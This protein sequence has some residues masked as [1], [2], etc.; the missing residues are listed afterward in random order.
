MCGICGITR[1][2][3]EAIRKMIKLL[4]HRGPEDSGYYIDDYI[5][6][7]HTRLSIIDI[8]GGHQPMC[9]EDGSIWVIMNGEIFNYKELRERLEK[10]HQFNTNSDTEVLIHLYEEFGVNMVSSLVG[11]FAFAIWDSNEKVLLLSRDRMGICPMYYTITDDNLIFSSEIK[12]ILAN[13]VE[14]EINYYGLAEYLIFQSSLKPNTLFKGIYELEPGSV[15]I[16]KENKYTIHKYWDIHNFLPLNKPE[17]EIISLIYHRLTESVKYSLVSDVPVGIYLSGGIDSSIVLGIM[18][19]EYSEDINAFNLS[20][21]YEEIDEKEYA[22]IVA[23]FNNVN[24]NIL[25]L[26]PEK[27]VHNLDRI[28]FSMEDPI[29]DFG[30]IKDYFLS[31]FVKSRGFKVVL[32]GGGSDELFGGYGG[33]RDVLLAEKISNLLPKK[34]IR[35]VYFLVSKSPDNLPKITGIR[36]ILRI[37]SGFDP[38]LTNGGLF[39]L[40]DERGKILKSI[41]EEVEKKAYDKIK[42]YYSNDKI[43]NGYTLT[44]CQYVDLHFYIQPHLIHGDKVNMAHA[45]EVR[46]PYL[47]HRLIETSFRI[48]ESLR[49]KGAEKYIIRK[50]AEKYRLLPKE[51][52]G[53]RKMGF[54]SALEVWFSENKEFKDLVT[55]T[56]Y[57][58]EFIRKMIDLTKFE[59]LILK[60]VSKSNWH[61]H[62]TWG[63]FLIAKWYDL[64]EV[65]NPCEY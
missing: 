28:V 14:P 50:L 5:S 44:R 9:N 65:S 13:G 42:K 52:I 27:V 34:L 43:P 45:V 64:F 21:G 59:R 33:Y 53:R 36:K 49:I 23:E 18:S 7:G 54:R 3:K 63:V 35:G 56:I 32:S 16:W 19:K 17:N 39:F 40:K 6:L 8:E 58:S 26:E 24:L 61:A 46:Y 22:K 2:D 25:T 4:E 15:L 62:R 38:Y 48:P 47:D 37:A 29:A 10:N 31:D 57:D 12:P 41:N 20:F 51:I 55:S 1:S 30:E 60:N 11:Q